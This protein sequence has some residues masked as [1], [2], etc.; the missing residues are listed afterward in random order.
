[1][2]CVCLYYSLYH[3]VA[4]AESNNKLVIIKRFEKLTGKKL[5]VTVLHTSVCGT[6]YSDIFLVLL[7]TVLN[8]LWIELAISRVSK[9][10]NKCVVLCFA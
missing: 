1:M 7:K 6:Y 5:P 3:I 9:I 4:C 10:K 8:L 2:S